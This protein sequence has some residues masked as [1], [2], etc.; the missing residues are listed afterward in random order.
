MSMLKP[1]P[2]IDRKSLLFLSSAFLFRI[3]LATMT[4]EEIRPL[5]ILFADYFFF[6]SLLLL[7]CSGQRRLLISRGSGVLAASAVILCGA[8]VSGVNT[9][10]GLRIVILFGVFAPLA[11]AHAKDIRR[12]MRFLVAGVFTN[13]VIALLAAWTSP[14]IVRALAVNPRVPDF[15]QELGRFAGIAGHPN[16]LGASA[17]LAVL[18]ALG[19]LQYENSPMRRW[20]LFVC[21]LV[22]TIAA[23]LSGS[24]TFFV[25]LVPASVVLALWRPWNQKLVARLCLSLVVL[26]AAWASVSYLA[27]DVTTSYAERLSKT[28]ADDY[29]N[30]GRLAM[31][32]LAMAEIAQKPI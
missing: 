29:E 19:L 9:G 25:A 32:A 5:S 16:D 2:E 20:G 4:F 13:C 31:A 12:N 18:I 15:G 11:V 26:F 6:S 27:S 21:I 22:C 23:I 14:G 3:G 1:Q 24:R 17:A 10:P 30:S 8:L 28:S 7:L